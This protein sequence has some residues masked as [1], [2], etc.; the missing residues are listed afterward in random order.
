MEFPVAHNETERL[1]R[2][3]ELN[4]IGGPE[5]EAL[6]GLTDLVA[7][8][9]N[10][11]SAVVSLLDEDLQRFIARSNLEQER[12]ERKDAFCNYTIT[13]GGVFIVENALEDERFKDNPQVTGVPGIRAYAGC[14]ISIDGE[15][16][17]GALCA[18]D[19]EPRS[20]SRQDIECLEQFTRIVERLIRS[21]ENA[22][23]ASEALGLA[24]QKEQEARRSLLHLEKVTTVS[25]VGGWE[26]SFEDNIPRW[27]AQTRRIH[28]TPDDYE[29]SLK[30]AIN[31]YAPEARE[32][33]RS[34]VER[35]VAEGKGW[36]LELPLTTYT[37]RQIWVRAAGEPVVEDGETTGLIGTFQ[38]I[39]QQRIDRERLRKSET[40]ARERSEELDV[41]LSTMKQGVSVFDSDGKLLL[42][43]QKY[44]DIFE[45]PANEIYKGVSLH[46]LISWEKD[47]GDFSGDVDET[48]NELMAELKQGKTVRHQ[49]ELKSG[50]IISSVHAAM[51]GGGWVG[52]HDDITQQ[53]KSSR[54]IAHAAHH[55]PLT[56]LANRAKFN[57]EIT[58]AVDHARSNGQKAAVMLVDLDG[59]KLVNDAFGHNAGDELLIGVAERLRASVRPYDHVAR[60]GGDEFAIVLQCDPDQTTPIHDIA[61]RILA[62]LERPFL[63]GRNEIFISASIGVSFIEDDENPVETAM[64]N[65]DCALY[66]IKE[67][68]KRGYRIFDLQINMEVTQKRLRELALREVTKNRDFVLHYQPIQSMTNN[69]VAGF[70]ALIRWNSSEY[71]TQYPDEFIPLAEDLGLIQDIGNWVIDTSIA[72]AKSWPEHL[73]LSLNV[74]PR[75]LGRGQLVQA[76]SETLKRHDFRADRLEV[77]IT[78]YAMMQDDESTI[79]ELA[80][81]KNLGVR[82]ALDDFGTG[83][84]SL[85]YLHRFPFDKLKIDRSFING[86]ETN[87]RRANIIRAIVA[88]AVSLGMEVT[89][90]G[91]ETEDQLLLLKLMGCT[92]AQGYYFAKPMPIEEISLFSAEWEN[93]SLASLSA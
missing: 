83:Y 16:A 18:L 48:V 56:G 64:G 32:V 11:A 17:L 2:L 88:M 49:F 8:S 59:F 40:L 80:Q 81:L 35:G 24:S 53:E 39:T 22:R 76:I 86:F 15:H 9:M 1:A 92:Y 55:D 67:E 13:N 51:P 68:G 71:D 6:E 85:S 41:T 70:E 28:E 47:R 29:P 63:I 66:K 45:K 79:D 44:L 7:R 62:S 72:Q 21:H 42:W 36:D 87:D 26:L 38:D 31:F 52:T 4:L 27:S 23:R 5:L 77:E 43:N 50:R 61:Q 69:D 37:G 33:I 46:Q 3:A 54:Q 10:C 30:N 93:E 91:I 12:T 65:A 60:L 20:F 14:P 84:S 57:Q 78:E 34:A 25:G 90:E 73:R 74:S 89:A 58:N 75:Q 19:Y 82:I